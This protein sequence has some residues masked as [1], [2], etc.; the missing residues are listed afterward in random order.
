MTLEWQAIGALTVCFSV[1]AAGAT[2]FVTTTVTA[3][4]DRFKLELLEE[5]RSKY[6]EKNSYDHLALVRDVLALQQAVFPIHGRKIA[7]IEAKERE[8]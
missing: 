8:E 3:K 1:L 7:V 4:L 2:A 6:V 5:L